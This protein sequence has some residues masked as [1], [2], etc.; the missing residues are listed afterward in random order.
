MDSNNQYPQNKLPVILENHQSD[1]QLTLWK[2]DKGIA[3]LSLVSFAEPIKNFRIELG[4]FLSPNGKKLDSIEIFQVKSTKAFVGNH[5]SNNL[6]LP[7]GNRVEANEILTPF[8]PMTLP[9]HSLVNL[10]VMVS[11]R[12]DTE[13]GS[14][15]GKISVTADNLEQPLEFELNVKSLD[16][17]IPANRDHTR[18]FD[19]ELWQ[20]PYSVAE[21]YD[22]SVFSKEHFEIL[23]PHMQLYKSFGGDT[24]TATIIEEAWNGQTYGKND[25]KFPSMVKWEL[26]EDK[27]FYFD[28]RDFDAWIE[29][30]HSLGIGKKI[31]CYSILPWTN[32]IVYYDHLTQSKKRM[33]YEI[34]N[35]YYRDTWTIFLKDFISHIESK[36]WK[37]LIY[38]GIDERG[39]D[40][41]VFEFLNSFLGDDG[42]PLKTSGA[43]DHL[44]HNKEI[45][46]ALD[47]L[48]VGTMAIKRNP[49]IFKEIKKLRSIN[50]KETFTYSCTG[51]QPGNFALSIPAE[52][53]WTILYS[54]SLKSDGFLRWAFDSWVEAPLT[55]CT[56][57][58]FESGDCFLVYPDENFVEK[59]ISRSS[60]RMEKLVEGIRDIGKIQY[61][62]ENYP[63]EY[64]KIQEIIEDIPA[65]YDSEN[66][67]L[68]DLAKVNILSDVKCIKEA[69]DRLSEQV[70][71]KKKAVVKGRC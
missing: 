55:D 44:D 38:L 9:E 49:N 24:I 29:F 30:N 71:H 68:T 4:A 13:A 19:L 65:S 10:W 70:T 39:F 47:V 53:Y 50:N 69:L 54:Q 3:H 62:A 51:H 6:H 56:H 22:V 12:A 23:R 14:Y 45:A 7:E 57:R 41:S 40:Q 1:E 15:S 16:L 37:E 28:Y 32:Q 18:Y 5:D 27:T 61:F 43:I 33:S 59:P 25:V 48:S 21:Y 66:Y 58:A 26:L 35:D 67:Y 2:N 52:S 36:G 46:L 17:E 64:I 8:V 63:D 34:G 42:L 20:N 11:V 31:I 60:T